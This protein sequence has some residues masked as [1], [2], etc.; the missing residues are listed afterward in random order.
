MNYKEET[1][2]KYREKLRNKIKELPLYCANYFYAH[3][4]NLA[5]RTLYE[6]ACDMSIFFYFLVNYIDDLNGL[7]PS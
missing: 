1:Q 3:S 6:Y 5:A 2:K 4:G 7:E